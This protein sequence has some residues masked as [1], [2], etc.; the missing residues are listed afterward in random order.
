MTTHHDR[1]AALEDDWIEA[2]RLRL[3]GHLRREADRTFGGSARFP[4]TEDHVDPALLH[5]YRAVAHELLRVGQ[6]IDGITEAAAESLRRRLLGHGR[7]REPAG[8]VFSIVP[9]DPCV[10]FEPGIQF[11]FDAAERRVVFTTTQPV[12]ARR[13][14]VPMLLVR[15]G[16]EARLLRNEVALGRDESVDVDRVQAVPLGHDRAM[17]TPTG[18]VVYLPLAGELP[19]EP[20]SVELFFAGNLRLLDQLACASQAR[21]DA[22]GRFQTLPGRLVRRRA[23]A[24]AFTLLQNPLR[25]QRGDRAPERVWSAHFF[26][27][28]TV[29][30]GLA[31][32]ALPEEIVGLGK[33]VAEHCRAAVGERR[34]TWFRFE[35]ENDVL[36]DWEA[37]LRG[38]YP[39]CVVASNASRVVAATL[40]ML[41]A[42]ADAL[43][44]YE[45]CSE[46]VSVRDQEERVEYYD[47]HQLLT[48]AATDRLGRYQVE[49]REVP[50]G[51]R[52]PMLRFFPPAGHNRRRPL[53]FQVEYVRCDAAAE[54]NGIGAGEIHQTYQGEQR[55]DTVAN[56]VVTQGGWDETLASSSRPAD[57]RAIL[58]SGGRLLNLQDFVEATSFQAG[59]PRHDPRILGSTCRFVPL[60]TRQGILHGVQ[61]DLVI[62]ATVVGSA[63]EAPYLAERLRH[64]L[65]ARALANLEVRVAWRMS[66]PTGKRGGGS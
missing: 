64:E 44:L 35:L 40:P 39:N 47:N 4:K 38:I 27:V 41:D 34:C 51:G 37:D 11:E 20:S 49:L 54:A 16:T 46:V 48:D 10:E 29:D 42:A 31:V 66:A 26:A 45:D 13:V 3:L 25:I 15:S 65:Q 21:S 57:T 60:R 43:P 56:V 1:A 58:K 7:M 62:D 55:V 61:V 2:T 52:R 6:R 17:R 14:A 28:A 63:A 33:A 36:A 50:K 32:Q 24:P 9:K 12:V 53:R 8:A 22:N 5:L 30:A 18:T 19:T 59:S 23:D